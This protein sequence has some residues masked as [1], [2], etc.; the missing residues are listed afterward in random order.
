MSCLGDI[1]NGK[2]KGSETTV[3]THRA[4]I[5]AKLSL[6]SPADL[7]KYAIRQYVR[8]FPTKMPSIIRVSP[9]KISPTEWI[10]MLQR[11]CYSKAKIG[12]FKRK[13][14]NSCGH[15]SFWAV[16]Q[17]VVLCSFFSG[18]AILEVS[19]AKGLRD[20]KCG[21]TFEPFGFIMSVGDKSRE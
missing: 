9:Y 17:V 6:R 10:P 3:Q 5:M 15:M 7:I 8:F 14:R 12:R 21:C 16:D 18:T 13:T 11:R 4:H 1:G 19:Q 20:P 2:R